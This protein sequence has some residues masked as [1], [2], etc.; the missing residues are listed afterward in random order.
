MFF[1]AIFTP[2]FKSLRTRIVYIPKST[3]WI[4]I[5][6]PSKRKKIFKSVHKK[7]IRKLEF[8]GP[9]SHLRDNT[10]SDFESPS[11]FQVKE[12]KLFKSV[13][14]QRNYALIKN[15]KIVMFKW[16]FV[17]QRDIWGK[18]NIRLGIP[19]KFPIQRKNLLKSV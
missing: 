9:E 19:I 12:K 11:N 1:V 7:E 16:T 18:Y 8:C 3:I 6:F 14:K 15:A 2:V 10:I 4:Q 17:V 5:K 13:Q